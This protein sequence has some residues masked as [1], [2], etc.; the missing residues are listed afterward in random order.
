MEDNRRCTAHSARTGKRC[1]K[2]AILGGTVCQTHGGGAPQV[3]AAASE[4]LLAL[5]DPAL[6]ALAKALR[7]KD[8]RAAVT[9]ARDVLDRAG[10]VAPR[11]P[12]TS[13]QPTRVI[14]EYPPD[15]R[16]PDDEE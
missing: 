8:I 12:P 11:T 3:K 13:G 4:R 6:A 2:A 10:H 14:Y 15:Y 1:G 5:V 9:A 16:K 7:H